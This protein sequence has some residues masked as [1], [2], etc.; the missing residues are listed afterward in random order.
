LYGDAD[1]LGLHRSHDHGVAVMENGELI[2][3]C[4]LERFTGVKHDGRLNQY[5]EQILEPWINSN[6]DIKWVLVNSFMSN[7]FTSEG[8]RLRIEGQDRLPVE[9]VLNK[10]ND[11]HSILTHEMAHIGTCLPFYGN[12]KPNSL[13][14]HIDGG[15]S[16]S[17]AS[18]WYFDGQEIMHLDH[19]WHPKL[20]VA[21]NNFN[22]NPLSAKILNVSLSD[23][24]AMPGK[25]MGYASF[26]KYSKNLHQSLVK[27]N[28]Y[29]EN[30][31]FVNVAGALGADIA[32]CMQR[33]LEEQVLHYIGKYQTQTDATSLYYS[34]G[35]ALNIHANVRIERELKFNTICIPPAPSDCGL[36]VGAAA[37]S[38]WQSG[39]Q[40]KI[41]S[42][43]L[44]S[45][46]YQKNSVEADLIDGVSLV[47]DIKQVA[48]YISAGE[49]VAV[50]AGDGE[51]GPRALGHRS[52]LI[53]PD[54]IK[55]R[56][57]LSEVMKQREWYRPVAPI[58]LAKI[59][60][61][62]LLEYLP[63]SN[64]SRFMLGAWKVADEWQH[65]FSGCIH[66][67]DSVRAQVV[68]DVEPETNHIFQLLMLLHQQYEIQGVI[69][70]SFN[71]RGMPIVGTFDQAIAQ[72]KTIGAKY[73]WCPYLS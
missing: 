63:N 18:A 42:A 33:E 9:Q 53:R 70:T 59:A 14:V 44:N 57:H 31:D 65:Y 71:S 49:V 30:A 62:A 21:V 52:L 20:K 66:A 24:L 35:A 11:T 2:F 5:A 50:F 47:R 55:L 40:I 28:W 19:S 29:I 37:F 41:H 25:L 38:E 8:G 22:A 51:I 13:L 26:G 67:D 69:N 3:S 60:K 27:N 7:Q 16:N 36:A 4:E 39:K 1:P 10:I 32:C 48:E 54:S 64:L 72:A 68:D 17:S 56:K 15:A 43:Y 61:L 46:V 6:D 12:F 73:L 34:G 45:A 58:M 23:H